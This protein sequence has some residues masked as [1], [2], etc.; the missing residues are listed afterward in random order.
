[1]RNLGARIARLEQEIS[2]IELPNGGLV[3]FEVGANETEREA[4]QRTKGDPW[5]ANLSERQRAGLIPVRLLAG[6]AGSL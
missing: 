6:D 4:W 5:I 2:E 3:L 1:M